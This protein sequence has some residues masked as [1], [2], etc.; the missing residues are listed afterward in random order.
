MTT[1]HPSHCVGRILGPVE[2][3]RDGFIDERN[4]AFFF[5]PCA[6]RLKNSITVWPDHFELRCF[7]LAMMPGSGL[8]DR[9]KLLG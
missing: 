8:K 4:L 7:Q 5:F 1:G 9:V 2:G 3:N 6:V